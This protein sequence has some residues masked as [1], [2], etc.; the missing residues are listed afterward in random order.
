ML[1]NLS[2]RKTA[3]IRVSL[4]IF[5]LSLQ[6]VVLGFAR[7]QLGPCLGHHQRLLLRFERVT[8]GLPF[9]AAAGLVVLDVAARVPVQ[10]PDIKT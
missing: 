4:L 2:G 9:H 6:I 7:L 5:W 8:F 3:A 1:Y 10:I